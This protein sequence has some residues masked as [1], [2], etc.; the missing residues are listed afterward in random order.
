MKVLQF[1]W[2]LN[3]NVAD[4]PGMVRGVRVNCSV[5]V[6]FKHLFILVPTGN[7][8]SIQFQKRLSLAK[9]GYISSLVCHARVTIM[10]LLLTN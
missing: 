8:P 2:S 1:C 7:V 10:L 9:Y 5:Q 6:I 3:L 4:H